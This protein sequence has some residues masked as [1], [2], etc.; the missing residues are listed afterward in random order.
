MQFPLYNRRADDQVWF[1]LID[2]S[3]ML[4]ELMTTPKLWCWE[5]GQVAEGFESLTEPS[6]WRTREPPITLH[7]VDSFL[8]ILSKISY[9]G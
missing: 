9:P 2:I 5:L 4:R 3:G 8:P 6:A 1:L 7:D